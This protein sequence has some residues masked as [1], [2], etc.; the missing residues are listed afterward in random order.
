MRHQTINDFRN[1]LH[2]IALRAQQGRTTFADA[3]RLRSI[4]SS[5]VELEL[6]LEKQQ[7]K[8]HNPQETVK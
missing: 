2:A 5:L 1:D 3:E 7:S 4:S 6:M 8:W